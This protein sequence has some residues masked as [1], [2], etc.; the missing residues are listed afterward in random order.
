MRGTLAAL[1]AFTV[2]LLAPTAHAA[3]LGELAQLPGTA[4]CL[5]FNGSSDDGAGTC[6]DV[7]G[8]EDVQDLVVTPDGRHVYAVT[9]TAVRPTLVAFSRDVTTGVLTQLAGIDGCITDD[10]AG[11]GGAGT[12]TD[13]RAIGSGD[14]RGL[15]V[16][17]DGRFVY[18]ASQDYSA[19]VIFAR[20]A[21]S[22]KLTQLP[23]TTG[24]IS[25]D[26]SSEDGAAT[27]ANGRGLSSANLPVITPD[28][29]FMIVQAYGE[30]GIAM[31]RRDASSGQ[32][33]QLDGSDGCITDDGASED[34]AGTCGDSLALGDG[35]GV[36]VS[37]DGRFVY[38]AGYNRDSLTVYA[39]N[40][41]TGVLTQLP[42]VQGCITLDGMGEGAPNAC[43]NGRAVDGAYTLTMSPAGDH[44]YLG[45]YESE[46][47]VTFRRN[48]SDGT[49]EQFAGTDGCVTRD[50][51]SEDGAG[52]CTDGRGLDEL[53]HSVL[54][55]DGRTLSV[56]VRE[57]DS[58]AVFSRDPASGRLTQLADTLGCISQT[59]A[60][61]T[62]E[63]VGTC[64]NGRALAGPYSVALSPDNAFLYA[65]NETSGS[66]A[67]F[68]QQASPICTAVSATVAHGG[69][70]NVPL[71]CRDGNGD[72]ITRSIESQPSGGSLG[73]VDQGAGTVAYTARPG[74]TGTDTFTF[75]AADA[76]S[77][78]LPVT[79]RVEVGAAP[80][81]VAPP[82]PPRP[83][84]RPRD[85]TRPRCTLTRNGAR[86]AQT[87]LAGRTR[88]RDL[89]RGRLPVRVRC[90]EAARLTATLTVARSRAR[91]LRLTRSRRGSRPITVGRGTGRA[92]AGNRATTLNVRLSRTTR[93]RLRRAGS[94]RLRATRM[95][96]TLVAVDAAG[97]RSTV[98]RAVR[99]SR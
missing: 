22:G 49:V 76:T 50:G 65:A 16:S 38:V 81:V 32:L 64:A 12:C 25:S 96:L 86:A 28:G 77:A 39:R 60:G 91:A 69:T 46:G 33:T 29:N 83:P 75:R 43:T 30:I 72:A 59:G 66:I 13:G 53:Y 79:A 56:A 18:M 37:P 23:G 80:A 98:R 89:L 97:N 73:S 9:S 3:V 92:L 17:S 47:I 35:N 85:T 21:A 87:T 70:V 20:D 57:G 10:G 19:V 8:T 63:G 5:S 52:T 42:G 15:T 45:A 36:L 84:V 94:R 24:C 54:S 68:S 93:S 58:I 99:I 62:G 48:A 14:G 31:F 67:A 11:E 27:C 6:T 34:G 78:G 41:T 44:I 55:S 40:T 2:C 4:G 1:T 51:A 82:P 61:G 90:N 95:T 71:T 7:R 88:V 74:F 26:G